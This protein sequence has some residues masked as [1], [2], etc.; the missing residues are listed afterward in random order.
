MARAYSRILVTGAGGFVGSHLVAS[1]SKRF[2]EARLIGAHFKDGKLSRGNIRLDISDARTVER[3]IA[4]FAPDGV[5]HLA[6]ISQGQEAQQAVRAT[7]DV[8]LGG[9]INLAEAMRRHV[10][11]AQLLWAPTI[12]FEQT[13]ADMLEA[14]RA[15]CVS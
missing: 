8:N 5:V 7:F 9:T 3:A 12:P 13:L 2:P 11:D 1:L 10:P 4:E 14:R 15:K 6:A